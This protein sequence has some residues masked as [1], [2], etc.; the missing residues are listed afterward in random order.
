MTPEELQYGDGEHPIEL[1]DAVKIALDEARMILPGIQALFGFQLIAA[2][3]ERFNEV[4]DVAGQALHLAALMLVALSCALAMTPAAYH[5]RCTT[6][7][8]K[9][10]RIAEGFVEA[11]MIPLMIAISIDVGLVANAVTHSEAWAV[12]LGAGTAVVFTALWIAY[13]R[14]ERRRDRRAG[15]RA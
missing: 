14:Y 7:S 11:C 3:N 6:V 13:P 4:F 2:F 9:L 1:K 15:R 5:R 12:S 10:L 8:V